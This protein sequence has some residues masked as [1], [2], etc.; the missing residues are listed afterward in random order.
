MRWVFHLFFF[1]KLK[2][3]W[4]YIGFPVGE[5][6]SLDD[7]VDSLKKKAFKTKS[8][9][10]SNS[11]SFTQFSSDYLTPFQLPDSLISV[12]S[13]P[14][15]DVRQSGSKKNNSDSA[16]KSFILDFFFSSDNS[17][18]RSSSENLSLTSKY[19]LTHS[20]HY[21]GLASDIIENYLKYFSLA[22]GKKNKIIGRKGEVQYLLDASNFLT[23]QQNSYEN[24]NN[25]SS[26]DSGINT[27]YDGVKNRN[28]EYSSSS[29]SSSKHITLNL[30]A[31]Q[32]EDSVFPLTFST[33]GSQISAEKNRKRI[34]V[35]VYFEER[36][37]ILIIRFFMNLGCFFLLILL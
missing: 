21:L 28:L 14:V 8:K 12:I 16:N 19:F 4:K 29:S 33:P 34:L 2:I 1:E 22:K 30:F 37:I 5:H 24:Q 26:L 32:S 11:S 18:K 25:I 35:D 23:F 36:F 20:L 10:L 7:N 31:S 6:L 13:S 15:R 27:D 17:N 9:N 3:I